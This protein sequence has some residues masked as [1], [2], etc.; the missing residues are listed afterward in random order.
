MT[1]IQH[2]P[3]DDLLLAHAAGSLE[4]GHSVVVASHVENC[5]HCQERMRV[6]EAVG[7]VLLDELPAATM[8]PD[9]LARTMAAIDASPQPLAMPAQAPH[10]VLP[11]GMSWPRSLSGCSATR[12]RWL[13]PGMR[14]SRVT[15][16][17]DPAANVFLL[18]IG[19]GKNLPMHTHS[20]S[21]LT[22][23]LYGTFHDG[24]ALFGPGD[25]DEADGS[26]H[27]QPVVQAGGECIC[28]ASVRGRVL[29]NGVVARTLGAL[30][31]M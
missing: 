30:V 13:G 14:W 5:A 6:F 4:R 7:G 20:D 17:D 10:P 28:L 22:Q 8:A 24:R 29:F 31:G 23:V 2:H 16:P 18:R 3:D 27:H 15:L 12:W 21:E 9:A 1:T 19:A 11:P 26:F 25:F